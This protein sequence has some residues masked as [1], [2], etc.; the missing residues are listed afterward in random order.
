MRNSISHAALILGGCFCLTSQSF[1]Q[2]ASE[3]EVI[4]VTAARTPLPADDATVSVSV[5]DEAALEDR[6]LVFAADILRAVPGLAVSRSGGPGGLTQIRA[7]GAEANHVLVLIDGIEA[8]SPFTGEADFAPFALDD[9]TRIE[10][11]RGEQSAQWGADAI[12]GVISLTTRRAGE[13][14]AYGLRVEGGSYDSRRLTGYVASGEGRVSGSLSAGFLESD[15]F[16]VSG[17]TS[18][19]DGY[20]NQTLAGSGRVDVTEAIGLETAVRWITSENQFDSDTDFDGRLDDVDREGETD[21]LFARVAVTAEQS[22]GR[23]S[24]NHEWAAQLTD[25]D[26][27]TRAD[28]AFTGRNDGQRGQLHYLVTGNWDQ[29]ETRHRLTGLIETATDET[30]TF[31][32]EGAGQ[33]Q[34][35]SV[36]TW[37]VALD[38]G[39]ARGPWDLTLSARHED[40]ELFENALTWRAGA[41]LA[42]DAVNGRVR[43]SAGEGVKN[44]GVFELFGFFPDFFVGNPDLKPESSTGWEIGWEQT[45][46][47]GAASWSAT[48][49]ESEL[50]DEI[51]TDFGV[52]PATARN[53][54]GTSER[55]GLEL[56]GAYAINTE[57]SITGQLTWLDS[58]ENGVAEIRRPEF[59]GSATLAWRPDDLPVRA[60]LTID[61]TGDQTDTDFGTFQPVTLDAYTLVGGTLAYAVRPGAELYVRGEN[62]LDEDYQDVFGYESAGRGLYVGLRLRRS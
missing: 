12:G 13:E 55:Q 53:A 52:F 18:E 47:D 59:L 2:E 46:L 43:V 33:N 7:R 1:A 39:V 37:A 19:T 48:W 62:L 4:L 11:A 25:T 26:S 17:T 32:G 14:P 57:V 58:E 44:P 56:E 23:V 36:D 5:L 49:F 54:D 21:N 50:E 38:Y 10:V 42:V 34:S 27:E 35:N 8:A 24:L 16:D 41:A 30:E 28:G 45:L 31:A 20:R 6:N 61:H 60:A 40:N 3:D 22:L 51:F 9:L 29:G 15:G